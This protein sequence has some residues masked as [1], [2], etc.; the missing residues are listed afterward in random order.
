MSNV[1]TIPQE[2]R[3]CRE[4][5]YNISEQALRGWLRQG[6]IPCV[7]IGNRSLVLHDNVVAFLRCERRWN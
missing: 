5:G 2:L 4:E 6:M 3:R 7:K 1:N